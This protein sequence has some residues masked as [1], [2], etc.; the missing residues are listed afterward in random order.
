MSKFRKIIAVAASLALA[1]TMVNTAAVSAFATG[2][3][4]LVPG[5]GSLVNEHVYGSTVD[6]YFF[7]DH[8]YNQQTTAGKTYVN[9][10]DVVD[11][12][13]KVTIS[14]YS[15]AK[16]SEFQLASRDSSKGVQLYYTGERRNARYGLIKNDGTRLTEPVYA[17]LTEW[18]DHDCYVGVK[19]D[20]G[21]TTVDLLENTGKVI[22]TIMVAGAL[23]GTPY[24]EF[25]GNTI[26][27]RTYNHEEGNNSSLYF[28]VDDLVLTQAEVS[29]CT[30][31]GKDVYAL[32]T[33]DSKLIFSG[34][35]ALEQLDGISV[36]PDAKRFGGVSYLSG[37]LATINLMDEGWSETVD[38]IT[39]DL[40]SG[41]T[42]DVKASMNTE[43]ES[44]DD[45]VVL[46]SSTG[47]LSVCTEA[48]GMVNVSGYTVPDGTTDFDVENC[49]GDVVEILLEGNGL[50]EEDSTLYVNVTTGRQ[51]TFPEVPDGAGS[52]AEIK[53]VSLARGG[54][55][56]VA[57]DLG[58][59]DEGNWLGESGAAYNAAGNLVR[60][61]PKDDNDYAYAVAYGDTEHVPSAELTQYDNDN[62]VFLGGKATLYG[63][64]KFQYEYTFS[65]TTANY[66]V[67]VTRGVYELIYDFNYDD[68]WEPVGGK[69][70]YI[71]PA[72]MTETS[73]PTGADDD[74]D[75]PEGANDSLFTVNGTKA[76]AKYNWDEK[77]YN[78][79]YS[80]ADAN[81][82]PI[83]IGG[84]TIALGFG[85]RW[86]QAHRSTKL[87]GDIYYVTDGKGKYGIVKAN[88]TVVVP[89]V[90]QGYYDRDGSTSSLIAVK[91]KNQ[92]YIYD[93]EV[94]GGG[95]PA[96]TFVAETPA[97]PAAQPAKTAP[98]KDPVAN[99]AKVNA[100]AIKKALKQAGNLNAKTFTLGTKVK[101]IA[102]K[103]FKGTKVKTLVVKSKKLTKKKIKNCLKGSKVKT[104]QV[105]VGSK[106]LNKKYVKKYKKIFTKKN[107]GKSVKVK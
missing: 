53:C 94:A 101:Q 88:G 31:L 30:Y 69:T 21:S 23:T 68:D 61:W 104:V 1:L 70:V 10:R 13:G 65:M 36:S 5:A 84:N 74:S 63:G 75:E 86:C 90:L 71:D 106:K 26:A 57:Y 34:D 51:I 18:R 20:S 100:K 82:N 50:A 16:N 80:I 4:A 11:Q 38:A 87:N 79:W 19:L 15:G 97:A 96:G 102:A 99:I 27:V 56:L 85:D 22:G 76:Y 103:S 40:A 81:G 66:Q 6:G 72:T 41:K 29:D 12:N 78:S 54:F 14:T 42:L 17:G 43:N 55:V 48:E 45:V 24:I 67:E 9:C 33:K 28:K 60:T 25:Y 92:W 58:E 89:V 8:S 95:F 32:L 7:I 35:E 91:Y 77:T 93:T 83:K 62:E 52:E 39:V 59:D 2:I 37:A 47:E 73:K 49:Y 64:D 107:C 3:A 46:L 44:G 105:K 98:Q